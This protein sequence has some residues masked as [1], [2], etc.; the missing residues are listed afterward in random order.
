MPISVTCPS[1]QSA[2]RLAD[3]LAGKKV[4]C[5]KCQA[6]ISVPAEP[7]AASPTVEVEKPAQL[8]QVM[9]AVT[10]AKPK[11][12]K[13]AMKKKAAP[14]ED[15]IEEESPFALPSASNGK[16]KKSDKPD[17]PGKKKSATKD[18]PLEDQSPFALPSKNS[19]KAGS[20]TK[21]KK[22]GCS[23]LMIGI[24]LF[25]GLGLC[26]CLGGVGAIG[27]WVYDEGQKAVADL[28]N[29]KILLAAADDKG[30]DKKTT[31]KGD[32]DKD[33]TKKKVVAKKDD[34]P[35]IDVKKDDAKKDPPLEPKKDDAKKDKGPPP[36]EP[37]KD[38]PEKMVPP[39]PGII[40]LTL[41]P[42]GAT[43]VD[44]VLTDA[45]PPNA[46][47]R[48]HKAYQVQLEA[49]KSYQID[50]VSTDFHSFLFLL[51]SKN[52]KITEDED[53]GGFPNARITYQAKTT[54]AYRIHASHF[55]KKHGKFT[56]TVRRIEPGVVVKAPEPPA[57]SADISARVITFR[58][59]A[60]LVGGLVWARDGKS[61]YALDQ[62]GLLTRVSTATGEILK[63]Q[64][65]AAR[66][67][68][69]AMSGEGLVLAMPDAKQVWVVD[70]DNLETIKKKI[71]VTVPA[72]CVSAGVDAK[73]AIV[74]GAETAP[75]AGVEAIDLQKGFVLRTYKPVALRSFG[76]SPDGKFLFGQAG[77]NLQRL[78]FFEGALGVGDLPS[79]AIASNQLFFGKVC[80]SPD[81][82]FVCLAIPRG[83]TGT[84]PDHPPAAAD[85]QRTFIYAVGN[86]DNIK[87]LQRPA[88]TVDAPVATEFNAVGIDPRNGFVYVHDRD[89]ALI[90]YSFA[91][92][93]IAQAKV[94]DFNA[95]AIS[96]MS[97]APTGAEV[98]LR[99]P[100]SVAYVKVNT[101]GEPVAMAAPVKDP[102][103]KKNPDPKKDP[104]VVKKDP[105]PKKDKDPMVVKK[106]PLKPAGN[107]EAKDVTHRVIAYKAGEGPLRS[108]VWAADGKSFYVLCKNGAIQRINADT[109][110]LDK[111]FNVGRGLG[112]DARLGISSEGLVVSFPGQML[113]IDLDLAGV[114]KKINAGEIANV[115]VGRDSS[116]GVVAVRGALR[117]VDLEKG[118]A[119][120]AVGFKLPTI[121]MKLAAD[122]KYLALA[123][124]NGRILRYRVDGANL[125]FEENSPSV[126][127]PPGILNMSGDGKFVCLA[128]G[129]LA[130]PLNHPERG[131]YVYAIE[132]LKK[133]VAV[134]PKIDPG[135]GV[136]V[137]VKGGWI[138][139]NESKK[140][141]VI[142][143]ATGVRK[144]EFALPEVEGTAITEYVV[145]PLGRAFLIRTATSIVHVK[146]DA[147]GGS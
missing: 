38:P 46:L 31:D 83:N 49:G 20:G 79:Y 144:G 60:L 10:S 73:Y 4:K 71:P 15:A 36:I 147:M 126:V 134:L 131:L 86:P 68:R 78:Q 108:P 13:P 102:D 130:P 69:L 113:V 99:G 137:D 39:P 128:G 67:G 19:G 27:W 106:E 11:K 28:K 88:L 50:L 44:S 119:V 62:K 72:Q 81:S 54:D 98:L 92:V 61:F 84:H 110:A 74:G 87:C 59:E 90:L 124:N 32:P 76:V 141:L 55:D 25:L 138:Y 96:E 21:A 117:I 57:N 122:G 9:N 103:P 111:S 56:L 7:V 107:I 52:N 104:I 125:I 26:G 14:K 29:Q 24:L 101:K 94:P 63:K 140:P 12:P 2:Y 139:A 93:K 45:D 89:Y 6:A 91:G 58:E 17:K 120:G 53:G 34:T 121:S 75:E 80:L 65:Y 123:D 133:P 70:P 132:D 40:T 37:K 136:G 135:R 82:Q 112:D 95:A 43:R 51:D 143:S 97:V 42:D 66:C 48:S 114:K 35:V 64:D 146:V 116:F 8:T 129:V 100:R 18:D 33:K 85:R 16:A 47:G 22:G 1:C 41:G 115:A 109:G 145:S 105:D 3:Q 142:F 127:T 77:Q 30:Q 118:V 23:G 5:Q